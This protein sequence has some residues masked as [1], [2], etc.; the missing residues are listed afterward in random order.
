V[1]GKE[2]TVVLTGDSAGGYPIY[3]GYSK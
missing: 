3:T 2:A 1:A